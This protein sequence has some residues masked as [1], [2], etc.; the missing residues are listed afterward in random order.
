MR[1][2]KSQENDIGVTEHLG[3]KHC[4]KGEELC[5]AVLGKLLKSFV[6]DLVGW[7]LG[8]VLIVWVGVVMEG[9]D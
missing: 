6:I 2:D 9:K 4:A 5:V 8:W 7:T 3:E 1:S